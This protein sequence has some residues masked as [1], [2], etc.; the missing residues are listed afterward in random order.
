MKA[1]I[2]RYF[3]LLALTAGAFGLAAEAQTTT[4]NKVRAE[5]RANPGSAAGLDQAYDMSAKPSTPAPAGYEPVYV[6]HYGRHGSRYAYTAKAYTV[7]LELLRRGDEAGNLTEYGKALYKA[8]SDFWEHA[9]YKVGDL[10]PLGWEQHQYIA[11]TMVKSFPSAFRKGSVVDACSSASV[12][13][14]VSMASFCAG[15]SRVAPKSE[16]YAHQGKLD[17]QATRPN[18]GRNP[19]AYSGPE[20]PFPYKESSEE[21]FLRRFPNY[22]DVLARLFK[23]TRK[24]LGKISAYDAFFNIYMLVAGQNSIPVEERIDLLKQLLTDEEYATLWETDNYERF[25]EYLPYRTPCSSIVDDI[26][27]KADERLAAGSR[28]ADLRFGH[29]HVLMTLLMIMDIE[30]FGYIPESSD[31]LVC[32]FR[33]ILSP[34][35]TNLQ[36]VFYQPKCCKKGETLVKVLLNGAE[37]NLGNLTPV[38]GPYYEWPAVREYLNMRTNLFVNR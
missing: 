26:V 11:S 1:S 28:G 34:M 21:F 22:N 23:D 19:F 29:D 7:P 18:E 14:I 20:I 25:R 5:M 13:S 9:E 27:A 32:A 4:P 24:C 16:V 3:L 12:R 17:I 30:G 15:I 31:D 10:T 2:L 38:K 6:S 36:F 35:A 37:T 8:L 33:T